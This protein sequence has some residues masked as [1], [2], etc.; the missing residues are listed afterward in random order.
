MD[1]L[2]NKIMTLNIAD[3]IPHGMVTA[4]AGVVTYVFRDHV[5]RD[6]VRFKEIRDDLKTL[7]QGQS[8]ISQII[9]DNHTEV[10]KLFIAAGQ[11]ADQIDALR[12]KR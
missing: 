1:F 6:D 3:F 2:R 10:L 5:K 8:D 11:H 9:S 4:L 12:E 7:V